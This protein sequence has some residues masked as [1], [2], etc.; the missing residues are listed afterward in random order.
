MH[1][2]SLALAFAAILLIFVVFYVLYINV[3]NR[4]CFNAPSPTDKYPQIDYTAGFS[5]APQT[6]WSGLDKTDRTSVM[7]I[8]KSK[9]MLNQPPPISATVSRKLVNHEYGKS[10]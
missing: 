4:A 10:Y 5:K 7:N 1:D 3:D 2:E 6:K 8:T 9:L